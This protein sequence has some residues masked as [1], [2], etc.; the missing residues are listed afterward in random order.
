M[1]KPQISNKFPVNILKGYDLRH[2]IEVKTFKKGEQIP[3][4]YLGPEAVSYIKSGIV[5]LYWNTDK[6][7]RIIV[8]FKSDSQLLKGILPVH[9][10]KVGK[11]NARCLNTTKLFFIPRDVILNCFADNV[12]ITQYFLPMLEEQNRHIYTQLK[13]LKTADLEERYLIFLKEYK[14]IYN[15]ISDRMIASY[16]GVHYTSL[17]RIKAKLI[18]HQHEK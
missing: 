1:D 2:K 15:Q 12:S 16:L 13:F 9:Y 7:K 8:D 18:E 5:I 6:E 10:Q 14:H 4:K 17:S 11:L 3:D